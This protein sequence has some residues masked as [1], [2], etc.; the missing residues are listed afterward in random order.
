MIKIFQR[1]LMLSALVVLLSSCFHE[2]NKI[3]ATCFDEVLN[4]DEE[5]VDCG[6]PN[7]PECLP[8]C[9]NGILDD[10]PGWIEYG[11]DCG[12]PCDPCCDNGVWD[13][14]PNYPDLSEEWLDCGG[15]DCLPCETC[16]NGVHDPGEETIIGG[17]TIEAI[18]CDDDPATDC[19]P[20]ADLCN[21]GLLNGAEGPCPDC[22]GACTPCDNAHCDNGVLD[23]FEDYPDQNETAVDCGG[24]M[25]LPCE[26]LCTDGILNGDEE[27]IDCGGGICVPCDDISLCTDG[28]QNGY[29]TG[30]DC[31][32]GEAVDESGCPPCAAFCMDGLLNG[33]ETDTDCGGPDCPPCGVEEESF[34]V[35]TIVD[36]D[37]NETFYETNNT[38]YFINFTP[39]VATD[40]LDADLLVFGGGAAHTAAFTLLDTDLIDN[41]F[42]AA[43]SEYILNNSVI[44][45]NLPNNLQIITNEGLT[46]NSNSHIDGVILNLDGI[47]TTPV[48]TPVVG[49]QYE[50]SGTFS[51]TLSDG[52][53]GTIQ[54]TGGEFYIIVVLI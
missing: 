42:G 22:G 37:G 48:T 46:Y 44:P 5:F 36:E 47:V 26:D 19:P 2:D 8:T 14:N 3:N 49:T 28:V 45:Q 1:V 32:D 20:C 10:E 7:C 35:Y 16:S 41:I 54:V 29:E 21:D 24:C 30:I 18:D 50:I 43:N 38:S 34:M 53:G 52:L 27:A 12:G 4:Q 11:V 39:G 9:D 25:C 33:H 31:Y 13:V 23:E 15:P 51:G 40:P 6:G 17:V